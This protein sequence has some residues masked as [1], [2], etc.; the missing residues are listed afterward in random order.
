MKLFL[1]AAGIKNPTMHAALEAMLPK[2]IAEC[3]A[4]AISAGSFGHN[5]GPWRAMNYYSG[6]GTTPMVELGWAEVGA[7]ELSA[8]SILPREHW[9]RW[10]ED[11]DVIL[12]NGGDAAF[13][14]HWMKACGFDDAVRAYPDKV[15]VGL[16]AGSMVMAPQI[17]V[18]FMSWQPTD[19]SDET[20]GLVDFAI[21]PH[22]DHPQ[23]PENTMAD[24]EKWFET[25]SVPAYALDDEVGITVLDGVV[26]VV[27]E[28][29]W[30]YFVHD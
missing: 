17:G 3:R 11:A 21:F 28:G 24:A 2:P 25:I 19:G 18:D 6:Q 15:Y 12:V 14:A 16:S 9:L 22:L 8:L 23:L 30:R 13:L 27:G 26:E 10:I 4:L 20:L 7:L 29:P 5:G 1:T